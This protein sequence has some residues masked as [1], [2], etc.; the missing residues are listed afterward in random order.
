MAT[1]KNVPEG[2]A[3]GRLLPGA[4]SINPKPTPITHAHHPPP[5]QAHPHHLCHSFQL[6]LSSLFS[7]H[8]S[9]R[10]PGPHTPHNLI[11]PLT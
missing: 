6:P 9:D 7:D 4:L 1:L 2:V 8:V 3:S 5:S 11:Y 10:F